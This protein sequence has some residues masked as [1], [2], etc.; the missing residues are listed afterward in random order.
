MGMKAHFRIV[1]IFFVLLYIIGSCM[2][3]DSVEN[4]TGI[5]DTVEQ[6]PVNL[7]ETIDL[8]NETTNNLTEI[9]SES[10]E[11]INE[12]EVHETSESAVS[13]PEIFNA[14]KIR[15]E[16]AAFV[17]DTRMIALKAG[18]DAAISAFN[19][20]MGP[21][22][23]PAMPVFAY[24]MEGK[25]LANPMDLASVGTNQIGFSDSEGTRYVQMMIDAA[26]NGEGFVEFSASNILNQGK[27]M[28]KMVYVNSV[29]GSWFIG[30]GIFLDND[31][32]EKEASPD[33]TNAVP[34]E[35][36]SHNETLNSTAQ[37]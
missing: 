24:D 18:K 34:D 28:K 5:I 7:S 3:T 23:D 13:E 30:S 26:K 32:E 16:L 8:F 21:Y 6:V 17:K 33:E 9:V 11:I 35:P 29:D 27:V 31:A 10:E 12:T 1:S 15:N 19:D 37:A 14:E 36:A 22:A 25:V 20:R 4:E 2:A